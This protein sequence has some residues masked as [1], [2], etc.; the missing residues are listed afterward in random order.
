MTMSRASITWSA[1]L[2]KSWLGPTCSITRPRTKIP[3]SWISRRSGSMVTTTVAFRRRSV[4]ITGRRDYNT[5]SI[6]GQGFSVDFT[7]TSPSTNPILVFEVSAPTI[8]TPHS[9]GAGP[10]LDAMTSACSLSPVRKLQQVLSRTPLS[11]LTWREADARMK[12]PRDHA[13]GR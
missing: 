2:G 11:L 1:L 12:S 6:A 13:M 7:D 10:R 4:P 8:V 5:G 9:F 3:P